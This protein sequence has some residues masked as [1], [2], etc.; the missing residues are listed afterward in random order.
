MNMLK[1]D[2]LPKYHVIDLVQE[3]SEMLLLQDY[4]KSLDI[5]QTFKF[6]YEKQIYNDLANKS[7]NNIG[8]DE[9]QNYLKT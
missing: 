7:S 9:Y 3:V 6:K 5:N 4:S 2:Y 1:E 8:E